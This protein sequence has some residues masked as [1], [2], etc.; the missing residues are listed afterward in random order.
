MDK[1]G[2]ENSRFNFVSNL[3]RAYDTFREVDP[4]FID[5]PILGN[6]DVDRIASSQGFI[7]Q[8]NK[9][10]LAARVLMT[11]PGNP[12]IYYGDELGMKGYR[13]EGTNIPGYGVVYDEYRRQPFMWGAPTYETYWLPSDGSNDYTADLET[14]KLDE[15]SLFNTYK[16]MIE[17]RKENPALMYGNYFEPYV[18]NVL[19]VQGYVRYYEYEDFKQAVLVIHNMTPDPYEVDVE[20]L[21]FLYGDSLNIDGYGTIILEIDPDLIEDYI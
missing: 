9:L 17:L 1:I 11:L 6:H 3:N 18:N 8:P 19:Q 13:Y 20:Y 10:A 7:N 15:T 12:F 5:A 16:M 2:M 4:Q 14:Q 21:E